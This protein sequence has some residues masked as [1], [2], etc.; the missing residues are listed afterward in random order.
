MSLIHKDISHDT[1]EYYRID[2]PGDFIYVM[3]NRSGTITF[4]ITH[5]NA[6][7][8]IF[9]IYEGKVGEKFSLTTKQIHSTPN[10]SSHLVVK[11]VLW[12]NAQLE[13]NGSIIIEKGCDKS[14]AVFESR[15]LL[16]GE[17]SQA[18]AKPQLEILAEDVS[19]SHAV[20]T[21]PPNELL[22]HYLLSRG[23]SFSKGKKLIAKGFLTIPSLKNYILKNS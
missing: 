14:G 15:H 7:V 9:G 18:M 12:D 16:M 8:R 10:A 4:E 6:S 11:S 23:I 22:L 20:A 13:H 19:C 3:K 21:S 2:K 1:Q 5:E 17:K